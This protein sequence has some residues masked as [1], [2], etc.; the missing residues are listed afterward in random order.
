MKNK[1]P[2]WKVAGGL[3]FYNQIISYIKERKEFYKTDKPLFSAVYDTHQGLIWC[4]GREPFPFPWSVDESVRRVKEYNK[5]GI[6]FYAAFN[7]TLLEEK[8]LEDENSN[9][10]L[11][12]IYS[13]KNG[14]IVANDLLKNYLRKNYP[15]F[16]VVASICFCKKKIKDYERMLEEYDQVVLHPDLNRDINFILKIE[17]GKRKK[18]SILVNEHC[19]MNCPYRK[20]HYH[21]ISKEH[22][23][24]SLSKKR[25]FCCFVEKEKEEMFR[26]MEL[27]Y[28]KRKGI[29]CLENE[30]IKF[31]MSLGIQKF[32]IMG[33]DVGSNFIIENIREYIEEP[34][35]RSNIYSKNEKR[36]KTKK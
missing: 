5:L 25:D 16:K 34:F 27:C 24:E 11:K 23:M 17:K 1:L 10:F 29:L 22:L 26:K 20:K 14:I 3:I 28:K 32:K 33:R 6:S 12:K 18:L 19:I 13:S 30:E 4:G 31:L 9:Y 15:K 36:R 7:N 35:A 21:L 8:H 2:E